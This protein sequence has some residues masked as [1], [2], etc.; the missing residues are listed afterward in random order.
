MR[1]V[2][3]PFVEVYRLTLLI[4]LG[5][6]VTQVIEISDAGLPRETSFPTGR[7]QKTT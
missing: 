4:T 5:S 7:A 6:E 3:K 1:S 2:D